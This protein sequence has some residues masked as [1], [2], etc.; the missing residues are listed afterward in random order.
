MNYSKTTKRLDAEAA[1]EAHQE[2]LGLLLDAA[3]LAVEDLR[4]DLEELLSHDPHE[5]ASMVDFYLK[6]ANPEQWIK[7]LNDFLEGWRN[8]I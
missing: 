4:R 5:Y 2:E 7:R 1:R 3:L 8:G 6:G